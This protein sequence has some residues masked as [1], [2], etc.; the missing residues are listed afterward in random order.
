VPLE[1]VTAMYRSQLSQLP[2]AKLVMDPNA[3]HFVMLDDPA[4]FQSQVN[5]FLRTVTR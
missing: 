3:L 2:A 4:F 5:D 1:R